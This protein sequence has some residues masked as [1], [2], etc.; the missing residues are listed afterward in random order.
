MNILKEAQKAAAE[1]AEHQNPEDR[2]DYKKLY[3][4]L[5]GIFRDKMKEVAL[6]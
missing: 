4:Y 2:E 1:I 5:S 3:R 6:N